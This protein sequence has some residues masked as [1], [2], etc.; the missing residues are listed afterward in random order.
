MNINNTSEKF[1]FSQTQGERDNQEDYIKIRQDISTSCTNYIFAVSDGMGGH[2]GGEVAA[3]IVADTFTFNIDSNHE[4]NKEKLLTLVKTINN[5]ISESTFLSP[6]L[7]GMGATLA[8]LIIINNKLN[9]LSIG[10]SIIY[11][12]RNSKLIRL[13]ADHSMLPILK[14]S[15]KNK[16]LHVST[17]E[18]H[19]ERHKLVSVLNGRNTE[20]IDIPKS[21]FCLKKDDIVLVASDGINVL[22]DS[23]L[24]NIVN[25]SKKSPQELADKIIKKIDSKKIMGQDNASVIIF[26]NTET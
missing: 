3:K 24:I 8:G 22:S 6:T 14:E 13:N 21:P 23:Q 15:L 2:P 25:N 18:E 17:L 16:K 5:K 10:D 9:W 1:G 12:L 11:L 19:P 7:S 20:L 4:I 26:K